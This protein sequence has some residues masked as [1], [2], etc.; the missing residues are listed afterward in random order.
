MSSYPNARLVKAYVITQRA[1][2]RRELFNAFAGDYDRRIETRRQEDRDRV[3]AWIARF[4][5]ARD[6]R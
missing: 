6:A 3:A 2:D 4:H 1:K 5:M